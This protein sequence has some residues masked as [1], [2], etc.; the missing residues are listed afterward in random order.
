MGASGRKLGLRSGKVATNA[1]DAAAEQTAAARENQQS[2]NR[3]A[4]LRKRGPSKKNTRE[5]SG[6]AAL[7][8]F[9]GWVRRSQRQRRWV[10]LVGRSLESSTRFFGFLCCRIQRFIVCFILN[11]LASTNSSRVPAQFLLQSTPFFADLRVQNNALI[12]RYCCLESNKCMHNLSELLLSPPPLL[13]CE[14]VTRNPTS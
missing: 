4:L 11:P 7:V 14:F 10:P 12:V 5:E 6:A 3:P 1:A 2:K 9:T 13:S 8:A